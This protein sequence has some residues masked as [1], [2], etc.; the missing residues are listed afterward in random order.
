MSFCIFVF[1][2]SL[3]LILFLFIISKYKNNE[4]LKI[5]KIIG[6]I[7]FFIVLIGSFEYWIHS[8]DSYGILKNKFA[9]PYLILSIITINNNLYYDNINIKLPYGFKNVSNYTAVGFSIFSLEKMNKEMDKRYN[10]NILLGASK[11]WIDNE[12]KK[13]IFIT[14]T[15]R[16]GIQFINLKI[17][18][19]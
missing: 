17:E 13:L 8:Q 2:I 15:Q 1:I 11:L 7:L 4:V 5:I 9:C 3:L 12:N 16:G 6:I 19:N 18:N 14:N 10:E